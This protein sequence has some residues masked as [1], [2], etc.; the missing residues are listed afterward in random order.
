[1]YS[2]S[3]G[4]SLRRAASVSTRSRVLVHFLVVFGVALSARAL[5]FL[6]KRD[7]LVYDMLIGDAWGYD[8]WA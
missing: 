6:A 1:V 4:H 3:D 2:K 7:A 5:H 8:Q